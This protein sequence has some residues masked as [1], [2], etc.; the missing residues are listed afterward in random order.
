[1]LK[2]PILLLI[3]VL[4]VS[5]LLASCASRSDQTDT[6]I[7]DRGSDTADKQTILKYNTVPLAQSE[8]MGED[9]INSFIFLGEST[10]YHMKSRGVLSG[11]T[12]TTQV[13]GPKSGTLMLD[14]TTDVCRIVYPES[15]EELDIDVAM[16]RRH[17]EYILLTFG[18][19]G[20]T[21]SVSHGAD[22]FKGCYRRLIDTLQAA[23]PNTAIILQSCFPVAK[24]MDMSGYSVDLATLNRYIDQINVWT[25]ELAAERDLGYLN[26]AE[27][28]KD[29]D[30][31]LRAEYQSGDG[32]HLTADAYR[33]ILKYIRTHGYKKENAYE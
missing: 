33:E 25:A 9:Y 19:N 15:G 28:L 21:R 20:A 3:S 6:E 18:L 2:R 1:M 26:T 4:T 24:N 11:G 10:T 8:D 31:T 30:G 27:I 17:P 23:S 32:Y 29:A 14:E 22:Y 7:T 16:R 5:A 13:W 12:A